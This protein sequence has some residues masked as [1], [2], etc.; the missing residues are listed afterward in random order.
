MIK[1]VINYIKKENMFEPDDL[2]VAGVSGGADSVCLLFML[3]EIQRIIPIDI[4]VVH[5]NHMIRSDAMQDAQYVEQLCK[6]NNLPFKLVEA[7][8]EEIA[9]KEHISTE[10]AGRNVRYN[11]FY[12]VLRENTDLSKKGKIAIAH[13]KN[14]CCETFLFNLLSIKKF[15]KLSAVRCQQRYISTFLQNIL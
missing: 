10:E 9:Q 12:E 14:D 11:A 1:K 13:N 8:V 4:R 6:Q 15:S 3:L 7:D 5:I 2:V